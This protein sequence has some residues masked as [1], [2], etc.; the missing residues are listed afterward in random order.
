M[1]IYLAAYDPGVE[2]DSGNYWAWAHSKFSR[3]LLD[4]L[5]YEYISLRKPEDPSTLGSEDILGGCANLDKTWCFWYRFFNGDCD[6]RGRPGRFVVIVALLNI[7]GLAD[8]DWSDFL[9]SPLMSGLEGHA[10]TC[11]MPQPSTLET[12]WDHP[13]IPLTDELRIHLNGKK[14]F[15]LSISEVGPAIG[16][17]SRD[18]IARQFHLEIDRV[19]EKER[20]QLTIDPPILCL[21]ADFEDNPASIRV[22]DFSTNNQPSANNGIVDNSSNPAANIEVEEAKNRWKDI[23]IVLLA[24][25]LFAVLAILLLIALPMRQQ[26]V[27][28]GPI[29]EPTLPSEL[30]ALHPENKPP[31][32]QSSIKNKDRGFMHY[33]QKLAGRDE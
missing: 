16:L 20:I 31:K 18:P 13:A 32:K 15:G 1:T 6:A 21:E 2:R 33:I 8:H 27:P 28:R 5:Y 22:I 17:I 14:T 12:A 24:L 30:T 4:K 7:S 23:A 26:L 10:S 9:M 19:K 25:T 11:P 3:Q 29:T